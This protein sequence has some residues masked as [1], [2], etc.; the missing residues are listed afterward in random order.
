VTDGLSGNQR[1]CTT[2]DPVITRMGD[3]LWAGKPS[4][5]VT[6]QLGRPSHSVL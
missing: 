4:G 1:N 2:S 5:Y 3:R 6:S